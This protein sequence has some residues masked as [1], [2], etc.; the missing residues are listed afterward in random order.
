MAQRWSFEEDYA[1]CKYSFEYAYN[2]NSNCKLAALMRALEER[3]FSSRSE[4]AVRKRVQTYQQIFIDY[5]LTHAT[6]QMM[7]IADAYLD[8]LENPLHMDETSY[9]VGQPTV[10]QDNDHYSF[11]VALFDG[12]QMHQH[13]LSTLEPAAPSFKELLLSH[14][15]KSGMK[16]SEV[17]RASYI[18]RDKFNHIINGRKGKKVKNTDG[19]DKVNASPRTVMQLCLGLQLSYEDA[20]YFMSCA[21]YAFNPHEDIDRVVVACIKEKKY[22]MTRVNIELDERHLEIFKEPNYSK[23]A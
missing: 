15:S 5:N 13:Y 2:I 9:N 22:S 8:M 1:I 4:V 11:D 23:T 20:V 18:S 21:G 14:I 17:Y 6:T 3:G 7:Q 12:N 10:I 16:D 19:N